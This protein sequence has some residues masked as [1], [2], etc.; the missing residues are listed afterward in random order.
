R[1]AA[2]L[3]PGERVC[4]LLV[5][6]AVCG[7]P[8]VTE[9]V[10]RAGVVGAGRFLQVLQVPDCT[11]V[12]QPAVLTQ[13][14]AG[15]VV[16]AVLEAL[17]PAQ[18]QVLRWPASDVS[19]DPAHPSPL[20]KQQ[21]PAVSP[22]QRRDGQPS[23]R[24]TRPAMLAQRLAALASSGASASTRTTGSVPDGLTSTRLCPPSSALSRAT[25]S[26]TRSGTAFVRTRT[27]SLTCGW[28]GMTAAASASVLP[29]SAPQSRSAATSPSPVTC[30]SR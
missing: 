7:P 8:C 3:A 14:D 22:S 19:D 15:R 28:R 18:Q 13:C 20:P 4:V 5:D 24:R 17:E 25:S 29:S 1:H 10:V 27:F 12:V 2:I 11:D 26:R 16:A 21:S 6:G 30:P 9:P 23:S